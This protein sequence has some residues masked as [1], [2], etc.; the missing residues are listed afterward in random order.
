MR[1]RPVR[2][3][4]FKQLPRLG[5][6]SEDWKYVGIGSLASF[7]L[8]FVLGLWFKHLP[9]GVVTGPVVLVILVALFNAV[10]RGKK[11]QWTNH[12]LKAILGRWSRFHRSLPGDYSENDWLIDEGAGEGGTRPY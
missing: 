3:N 10:Q 7:I 1:P 9:V 8:P 5:V 12:M 4:I 2:P 11:P 6:N